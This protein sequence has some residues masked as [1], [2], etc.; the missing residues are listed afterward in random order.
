[1][2]TDTHT[3]LQRLAKK[4]RNQKFKCGEDNE[5]YSVKLKM[6]YFVHYMQSN[7]DDSP[8]YIFDSSFGEVESLLVQTPADILSSTQHV[9]K[10]KL[11]EDYEIPLY[12]RDDLFQYAGEERRPPYRWFVMGPPRSGTGIHID[13][14]GTSAWNSLVHGIK[15]WCLF[16]TNT[17]RE[18]IKVT[19]QEGGHQTDEAITWFTTIYPRAKSR[20]W[21]AEYRPLEIIQRAGETVFVP[22]GWWYVVWFN[23]FALNLH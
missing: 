5:G 3:F 21:P 2:S 20:E 9:R 22:G 6:K 1:M 18:M 8:L 15:R 10:K 11:L 19:S 13:P 23:P 7:D 14:L 16:P 12:F 17:P 4:Y